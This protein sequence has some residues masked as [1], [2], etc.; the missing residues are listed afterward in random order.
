MHLFHPAGAGDDAA[1]LRVLQAP[2]QRHLRH[3]DAQL[4]SDGDQLAGLV[5]PPGVGQGR[6][7]PFILFKGSAAA[8][9]DAIV[10]LAGQQARSQRAEDS[11]PQPDI[12]VEAGVLVLDLLAVEHVVLRLLHDRL[13]QVMLIG[14]LPGF[15][16]L[17]RAPLGGAPVDS[18]AARDDVVH[19]PDGLFDGRGRVGA[20]AEDQIDVI[21][22]QA[23]EGTVHAFQEA[24]A[25]E[26]VLLVGPIVQPPEEL[27]GD[28]VTAAP[29]GQFLEH[30]AHHGLGLAVGIDLGVVKKV[31]ARGVGGRHA[32]TGRVFA[33][34]EAKG[35]P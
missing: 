16:D 27:G 13:V 20:V 11:G 8:G 21:E 31:D 14:D 6:L 7:E 10:V 26:G 2:G 23:F 19:G 17:G 32:L 9:G 3:A 34:L 35:D 5:D 24:L 15:H 29:P 4:S 1:H 33:H 22:L 25:V 28:Q 12:P 18:L 30:V